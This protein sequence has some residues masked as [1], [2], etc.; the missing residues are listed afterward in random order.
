[1]RERE[2]ER[3]LLGAIDPFIIMELSDAHSSS[4]P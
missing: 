2:R 4:M 3:E 1:M